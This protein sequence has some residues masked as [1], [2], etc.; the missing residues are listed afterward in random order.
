[1]K[2]HIRYISSNYIVYSGTFEDCKKLY[3]LYAQWPHYEL[4]SDM[5]LKC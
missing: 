3:E 5:E 1:M 4:I 2:W